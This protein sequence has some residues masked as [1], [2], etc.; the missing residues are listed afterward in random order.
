M[1]ITELA[2]TILLST[3][4]D[5]KLSFP[6]ELTDLHPECGFSPP[7]VPGRPH[8]LALRS[9]DHGSKGRVKFPRA[10]DF[11]NPTARG[12]ALHF[13]ANHELLAMELMALALL[14]FPNAPPSFRLGI[15][16]T[17]A[18][19]QRHM[20]MYQER[21][22]SLSIEFG[23][24]PVNRY[25]WDMLKAMR[26][27]ADYV[28]RMSLTFEQANLD[29]ARYYR[30]L[31]GVYDD[32]I[33]AELLNTV[34]EE[35]IGHVKF[36]VQWM[37]SWRSPQVSD[38]EYFQSRMDL[39]LSPSRAKGIIFDEDARLRAGFSAEYIENLKVFSQSKGRPPVVRFMNV[40][41]EES[42]AYGLGHALPIKM[43]E[44]E[45][46][47]APLMTFLSK[48]DDVVLVKTMPSLAF[49]SAIQSAGFD[50]PQY[51]TWNK[52]RRSLD[53]ALQGRQIAG[54]QPW[55]RCPEAAEITGEKVSSL[56]KV[57]SKAW[58]VG[59]GAKILDGSKDDRR[60]APQDL[61]GQVCATRADI[62]GQVKDVHER[63]YTAVIKAPFGA[64]GRNMIRW[65]PLENLLP[66]YQRWIE[67]C[68]KQQG[69]VVVE[70]WLTKVC[71]L[72]TL[73]EVRPDSSVSV[74][75]VSRFLT[76][77]NG[78]YAGHTIGNIL[79]GLPKE[80]AQTF[81]S[82]ANSS[83]HL[84]ELMHTIA[85]G[86][87]K[88]LFSEGYTGPAGIDAFIYQEVGSDSRAKYRLKPIVEVNPRYTMGHVALA[89]SRRV[90]PTSSGTWRHTSVREAKAAGFSN[91][92]DFARHLQCERPLV[93][94]A[95]AK[96]LIRSGILFTNEPS[97]ATAM[98]TYLDISDS[99]TGSLIMQTK[100]IT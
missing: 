55:G 35:E 86:V 53:E 91:F 48:A 4:I 1:E 19:E 100:S 45:D 78:Q 41:C 7:D 22:Q 16:R 12:Q 49:A 69:S 5:E 99:Q 98:L 32:Q 9:G 31:C 56:A 28:V 37:N 34:Y 14:L 94:Q 15:A 90:A 11:A 36:G 50:L 81:Q 95:G 67:R 92:A 46:D 57:F 77:D 2:K 85:D 26:E 29:Y 51:R 59:L 44:L 18:E 62:E 60:L 43:R 58:S 3:S 52:D 79:A 38:W 93:L 64:S 82:P 17:I 8:K 65:R 88:I 74:I 30:D 42:W 89:L 96:A 84:R 23:D 76:T 47:L 73:F 61:Y 24:L 21:M 80:L 33:T 66:Q 40:G 75:G 20:R 63:G 13:F 6:G 83:H 10:S 97:S 27:P 87:G 39:P 68:L 70:P 54:I 71:D 25:F 72:S